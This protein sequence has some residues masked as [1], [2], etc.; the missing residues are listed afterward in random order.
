MSSPLFVERKDVL[1][2]ISFLLGF[3]FSFFFF[4][5]ASGPS[6]YWPPFFLAGVV[7]FAV[8]GALVMVSTP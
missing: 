5:A 7:F 3:V 6:D 2:L 1:L 8:T 4:E